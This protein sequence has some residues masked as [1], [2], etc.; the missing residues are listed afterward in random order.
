MRLLEFTSA[1]HNIQMVGRIMNINNGKEADFP[2]CI[3]YQITV[4]I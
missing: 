4:A 3:N 2:H 1:G